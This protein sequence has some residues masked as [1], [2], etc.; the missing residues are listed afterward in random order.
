[1]HVRVYE[2]SLSGGEYFDNIARNDGTT[3]PLSAPNS[4]ATRYTIELFF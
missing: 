4:G 2:P 3:Q 1:M